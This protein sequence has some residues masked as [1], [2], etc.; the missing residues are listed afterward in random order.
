MA[1]LFQ[2]HYTRDEVRALLPQV[3]GWLQRLSELRGDISKLDKKL[4]KLMEPGRDLGGPVVE[5]WVRTVAQIKTVLFEFVRR[6]IQIK[7]LKR[8]LLDFPA[9]MGDKE[10]FLCWEHGEADVEFWHELDAGYAGRQRLDD[11]D[12]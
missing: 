1:N 2:Q 5:N 9:L 12:L 7:D 3:R 8:G 11:L 4:E 10:V 6:E